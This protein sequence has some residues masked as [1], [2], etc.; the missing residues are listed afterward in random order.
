ME[1]TYIEDQEFESIDYSQHKLVEGEYENC[2]FT[3]CNFSGLNL[4]RLSFSECSFIDCNLSMV[5]LTG[6]TLRDI[7]FKGC[8]L[9]G[10]HFEDCSDF[11]F[12]V[13][14]DN[15]NLNLSSFFKRKLKKTT[16]NNTSLQEVDFTEA[17]LSLAIFN[18]CDMLG[19]TFI[20]TILEKADFRTAYNYAIDPEQNRIKKAKFS[21]SGVSG[22]L[23]KYDLEIG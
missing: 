1:Q 22:L 13:S 8:K 6:T 10:L 17:D 15:C 21:M 12:S 20:D 7:K 5:K 11:L 14:F 2:V 9:L 19:A 4:S 16:F 3:N 23:L 18:N